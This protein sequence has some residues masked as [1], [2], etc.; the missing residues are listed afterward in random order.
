MAYT[1]TANKISKLLAIK[2]IS[3][4]SVSLALKQATALTASDNA[5][6]IL[7]KGTSESV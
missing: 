1:K 5:R 3:N 2:H 6:S 7:S 4:H